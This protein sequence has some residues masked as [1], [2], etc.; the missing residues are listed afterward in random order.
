MRPYT[1][2]PTLTTG[3]ISMIIRHRAVVNSLFHAR[4][5]NF[6]HGGDAAIPPPQQISLH[7]ILCRHPALVPNIERMLLRRANYL[8][9]DMNVPDHRS[10]LEQR[11]NR[12]EFDRPLGIM[13][14]ARCHLVSQRQAIP[15]CQAAPRL[16][17]HL[18]SE[19]SAAQGRETGEN[20]QR[21]RAK[22]HAVLPGDPFLADIVDSAAAVDRGV[23]QVDSRD[24]A[25]GP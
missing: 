2:T 9:I 16:D 17:H 12:L 11:F 20:I 8:A 19:A 21:R 4:I 23:R 18:A 15:A 22:L 14:S 24:A 5:K 7:Q 3:E 25:L 10:R 13:L 1:E 6:L